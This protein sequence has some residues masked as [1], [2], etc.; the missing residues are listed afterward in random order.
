MSFGTSVLRIVIVA[1][2]GW[3]PVAE[4][5]KVTDRS[6]LGIPSGRTVQAN[7]A[8]DWPAAMVTVPGVVS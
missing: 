3:Y 2:S 6:A 8:E 5:V 4:A 1:E 7:V